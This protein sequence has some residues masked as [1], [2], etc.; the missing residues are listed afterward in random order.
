MEDDRE[1]RRLPEGLRGKETVTIDGRKVK[2]YAN[3]GSV[4]DELAG[5][6]DF[7]GIGTNNLSQYTNVVHGCNHRRYN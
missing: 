2:Q 3:I 6:V 5:P 4:G 7:F 1:K